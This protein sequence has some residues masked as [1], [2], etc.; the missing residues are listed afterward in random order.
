[1]KTVRLCRTDGTHF[2]LCLYVSGIVANFILFSDAMSTIDGVIA[3]INMK[4]GEIENDDLVATS[5]H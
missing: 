3:L 2:L 4:I 5:V 1:M